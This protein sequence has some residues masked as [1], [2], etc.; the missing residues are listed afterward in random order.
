LEAKKQK[1]RAKREQELAS[2]KRTKE[3][4]ERYA[5][6]WGKILATFG[7]NVTAEQIIAD[8]QAGRDAEKQEN[9]KPKKGEE[10]TKKVLLV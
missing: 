1:E 9:S 3:E 7:E 10:S 6:H 5:D 8:V 4:T 2:R